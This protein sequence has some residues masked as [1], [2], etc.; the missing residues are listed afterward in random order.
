MMVYVCGEGGGLQGTDIILTNDYQPHYDE[1]SMTTHATRGDLYTNTE[2]EYLT[3]KQHAY[4]HTTLIR[5]WVYC[6]A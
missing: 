4:T 6:M 2:T 1:H 5:W 3:H